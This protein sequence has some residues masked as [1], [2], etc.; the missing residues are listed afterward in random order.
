MLNLN[1][2]NKRISD[3][4]V[5]GTGE[6]SFVFTCYC[7]LHDIFI[8]A[9]IVSKRNGMASFLGKP[10]FSVQ[11]IEDVD[12]VIVVAVS[13]KYHREIREACPRG[14]GY[15]FLVRTRNERC[16]GGIG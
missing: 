3:I 6:Y 11:E 5:W 9:Y 7:A 2:I 16:L 10:V 8:K 14:G 1:E 13:E 4:Y 12:S 15:M